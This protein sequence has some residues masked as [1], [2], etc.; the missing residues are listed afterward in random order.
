MS[1]ILDLMVIIV[2]AFIVYTSYRKGLIRSIIELAGYLVAFLVSSILSDPIGKWI[3]SNFLQPIVSGQIKNYITSEIASNATTQAN[4]ALGSS[5]ITSFANNI[6]DAFKSML[7]NYNISTDSLQN[8]AGSAITSGSQSAANTLVTNVIDPLAQIVS[9]GI[10]FIVV[11]ALCM[12]A[13]RI[14][15]SMSGGF[16][17]IPIIGSFNKV[18]G[19]IIGVLKSVLVLFIITTCIAFVIPM[20]SLQKNPIITK[21]NVSDST[22]FKAIYYNNPITSMLIKK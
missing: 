21:A 16:S 5:G 13:V 9:R 11:F 2:F 8:A 14:V 10:A 7:G 3:F 17:K 4:G 1:I 20:L 12:I 15:A 6:P 19:A 18:G 22:I